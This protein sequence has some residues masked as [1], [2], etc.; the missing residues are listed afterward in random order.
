MKPDFGGAR[1]SNAGDDFHELWALRQSLALLKQNTLLTAVTVEGLKAKDETGKSDT[2]DGVDCAY[3]YGGDSLATAER[4]VIEQVKY[5]AADPDKKWTLSR[6]TYSDSQTKNNSIIRKLANAFSE[7]KKN[8]LNLLKKVGL[9]IR[10]VSNQSIDPKILSLLSDNKLSDTKDVTNLIKASG[11]KNKDFTDF[12]K[13]LDFSNCGG[14]SR[15]AV[16]ERVITTISEWTEDDAR[17]SVTSLL[18]FIRRKMMMPESKKEFI[19]RQSI[20]AQLG[21]SDPDALFPCRSSIKKIDQIVPRKVAQTLVNQLKDKNKRICLHGEGGCG[22]T[23]ALQEI[24]ELLPDGSALLIFDCYG[25]GRYLDSDAYRHRPN[26]AFLQLSNE[27]AQQF[28]TPLLISPSSNINYPKVFKKRLE[29]ASEVVSSINKNALLVVAIDAADNSVTAAETHS[30]EET[31]FVHDFFRLGDLPDNVRFVVTARTGRLDSLK[32][33]SSFTKIEIKGFAPT[34]TNNYVKTVWTDAPDI[35]IEDFHYLSGG[36]PRVQNYALKSAGQEYF[37]A[38]EYLRPNGKELPDIFNEQLGHAKIKCG[39]DQNIKFFCAG[40]VAL[41][42]PIPLKHLSAVI[43]LNEAHLRDFCA[44]L[45]PGIRLG[46]DLISFADED[47]EHFIRN[48]A[49]EYLAELQ[50]RI[51]EYLLSIHTLDAYAATHIAV[52]LLEA[53][54]GQEIINLVNAEKEPSAIGD[55]VLRREAQLRRLKLAMKVCQETGNTA[56][57][58]LILLNGADALKTDSTIRNM[59]T[60]NPDL[61]ANFARDTSSRMILRDPDEI[62]NHGSL[63]FHMLAYDSQKEE[64]IM[65]REGRRQ[66][67]AWLQRRQEVFE[68]QKKR[69]THDHVSMWK[70]S[71]YDIAAETEADLR[72]LG[73]KDAIAMLRRW[74]PKHTALQV[75]S[76][77][78]YKLLASGDVKLLESCVREGEIKSPWILFVLTPLALTSKQLDINVLED[79]LR[80]LAGNKLIDLKNIQSLRSRDDDY[81]IDVIET[82]LT[83]C[84]IVINRDGNRDAVIPILKKLSAPEYRQYNTLYTHE[85]ALIDISLRAYILLEHLSGRK[86][87]VKDYLIEPA[88]PTEKVAEDESKPKNNA[89]NERKGELETFIGQFFEFYET[90]A[91][92]LFGEITLPLSKDTID[93]AVSRTHQ[94]NYR[95]RN[96]HSLPEMRKRAALSLSRLMILP[97]LDRQHLMQSAFKLIRTSPFSSA[98]SEV[99]RRFAIDASLHDEILRQ[100]TERVEKIKVTRTSAE[101]KIEALIRLA[102]LIMPISY[103]EAESFFNDALTVA[104]DTNYDAIHEIA[105]FTPL[106]KNAMLTMPTD[107]CR[108]VACNFAILVSDTKIR[109]EGNDN[110][111]SEKAAQTLTNLDVCVALAAVARW[112]DE[113]IIWR[114]IILQKVLETALDNQKLSPEQITSTLPL[115]DNADTE[116]IAQILDAQDKTGNSIHKYAVYE[117]IA[118]EELLR[119]GQGKRAEIT[120]K[121]NSINQNSNNHFWQNQLLHATAFHET[122]TGISQDSDDSLF[123]ESDYE[124]ARNK[125]LNDFD[126]ENYNFTTPEEIDETVEK[127]MCSAEAANTHLWAS[128]ILEK[129]SNYVSLRNRIYHLD[130]LSSGKFK[131]ISKDEISEVIT[132]LTKLWENSPSVEK[133][134]RQYILHYV[135]ENLPAYTR[136][137]SYGHSP[138]PDLLK[139]SK[140]TN[141]QICKTL[142]EATAR[143]VD[144]LDAPT[145]YALVGLIGQFCHSDTATAVI[146]DYSK[147]LVER[148]PAENRDKWDLFDIPSDSTKGLARYIYALM[149]D[150]DVRNRWRAAHSIRILARLKDT[151]TINEIVELYKIKK[152]QSYRKVDAAFYWMASRLW[153]VISIARIANEAPSSVSHLVEWLLEIASEE[154]FPHVILREFAKSAVSSLVK[155]KAISLRSEQQKIFEQINISQFSKKKPKESNKRYFEKYQYKQRENRRFHFDSLDTIPYWYSGKEQM[156]V[157]LDLEEFMDVAEYWIVDKWGEKNN[158]WIWNQESRKERL[159]SHPLQRMNRN[160]HGSRPGA[161]RYSTYLE[162]N[163]MWCAI[164]DLLKSRPLVKTEDEDDTFEEYLQRDGLSAPPFWLADFRSFK[165]LEQRFWL[166]PEREIESWVDNIEEED[167]LVE[168]GMGNSENHIIV[169]SDFDVRSNNFSLS[170]DIGTALVSPETAGALANA[171]Q[172]TDDPWYNYLPSFRDESEIDFPPYKLLGWLINDYSE[173]RLDERDPFRNDITSIRREPAEEVIS[174]LNLKFVFEN[175]PSWLTVE[176]NKEIFRYQ[177]WSDFPWDDYSERGFYDSSV[178]SS[179]WQLYIDK[180]ALKKF[181]DDKGL[182]LIVKIKVIRKN[183]GYEYS[184]YNEK[185][186][187]EAQFER[188]FV[189][190][191]DRSIEAAERHFGTW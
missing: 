133:W 187:K 111:P 87:A 92:I 104:S 96:E 163:A 79:C 14:E 179:G 84:E 110:F 16:E 46:D 165:P 59:L 106:S 75:A 101:E 127:L 40:L 112:E 5:S 125:L 146:Q 65:V 78:T 118:K 142:I 168:L 181:L 48:E 189:L 126:W 32:L 77:L 39:I 147:Q 153:L 134:N 9:K 69:D 159:E 43:G 185:E 157:N 180:E 94:D 21:I 38:I 25:G 135:T 30:P 91:K 95:L 177:S 70:I 166:P 143:H 52:A 54:R 115:L 86:S 89:A 66:L 74:K 173:S 1:G 140:G 82:V 99:F 132:K 23:T 72:T 2:W 119:F 150:I 120:R 176:D 28:R 8:N 4:I 116:F 154:D 188:I 63:L 161:E 148:I 85:T 183:K 6:L 162:W 33:P 113:S 174:A 57:A 156:F 102:R 170:V 27:L 17:T 81:H 36:N 160:D 97:E 12:S 49:Q 137:L 90:R 136:Y 182:D 51:A 53:N 76:I 24:E 130:T 151:S 164:G 121:L 178:R 158:P 114:E 42:R 129:M 45:A 71:H 80:K 35:W 10:F 138:L 29:K 7:I 64:G 56:E 19:T 73:V 141:E 108:E 31:S 26:D 152:E 128:V 15:F 175:Q 83:A 103:P 34:E 190:R 131:N 50:L 13:A 172:T 47:F 145:V 139:S 191:R 144:S 37:N 61:A 88:K 11:L 105:L 60:E 62:E 44:D 68:E 167:F 20:L 124:A 107:I 58:M 93:K 22:K 171:F 98:E 67:R 155:S 18:G 109:L 41:P 55:P 117:E 186:T 100:V 184:R 169:G 3:Y 122:K 149:S 123:K